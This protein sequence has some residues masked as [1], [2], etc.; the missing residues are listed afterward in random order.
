M[1][2]AEKKL[3]LYQEFIQSTNKSELARQ[4]GIDRSYMYE[5]VRG[6]EEALSGTFSGH[7][8][9]RKPKGKP[10][11]LEEALIVQKQIPA[12][13]PQYNG[14]IECGVK[15]FK[16]VFY[17]VFAELEKEQTDKEKNLLGRIEEAVN[18]TAYVMDY[19]IPPSCL[20][21]VTPA[22][23]QERKRNAKIEA[24]QEYIRTEQEK[25][26]PPPWEKSYWEVIKEAKGLEKLSGLELLT[27]FCFFSRQPLRTIT[28]LGLEGVG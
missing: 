9:G 21:G 11:T 28:K 16:N 27:K 10:A 4:W 20:H 15:E 26:N 6:C 7:K 3:K 5:I 2:S 24:N 8:P 19:V 13:I 17:N 1:L 12:C 25:P 23:V 14:S 22:D 18:Q